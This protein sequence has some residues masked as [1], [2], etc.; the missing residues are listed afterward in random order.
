MKHLK[1]RLQKRIKRCLAGMACVFVLCGYLSPLSVLAADPINWEI[2]GNE[3]KYNAYITNLEHFWMDDEL[4]AKKNVDVFFNE[5]APQGAMMYK[6]YSVPGSFEEKDVLFKQNV[7]VYFKVPDSYYQTFPFGGKDDDINEWMTEKYKN[8][9]LTELE[10]G[11]EAY[12]WVDKAYSHGTGQR[13]H[14][15]YESRKSS[16]YDAYYINSVVYKTD[17]HIKN[18]S[19]IW[20]NDAVIPN[21]ETRIQNIREEMARE[22]CEALEEIREDSHIFC[23][24]YYGNNVYE[25]NKYGFKH[26]HTDYMEKWNYEVVTKYKELPNT[27]VYYTF[28]I[29]KEMKTIFP[30][31]AKGIRSDIKDVMTQGL[32]DM[33]SVET[34]REDMLNFRPTIIWEEPEWNGEEP[35][36][37]EETPKKTD[38]H[39]ETQ[40]DKNPGEFTNEGEEATIPEILIVGAGGTAVAIGGAAV[41]V[42]TGG[43]AGKK[44]GSKKKKG[45]KEE[46]EEEERKPSTFRMYFY[47]DFG[48][49]LKRGEEAKYVYARMVETTFDG[50]QVDRPDLS[51]KIVIS[52]GTQSFSVVEQGMSGNYKCALI[53][54]PE[55]F[56]ERMAC[57]NFRF[58]GEGGTY[59]NNLWFHVLGEPRILFPDG[60]RYKDY[61]RIDVLRG[62][63]RTYEV[64]FT[65]VDFINEPKIVR[66]TKCSEGYHVTIERLGVVE[67]RNDI[68]YKLCI[69]NQTY[70]K[71]DSPFQQKERNFVVFE[72][73]N[74]EDHVTA[75]VDIDLYPEGISVEVTNRSDAIKDDELVIHAIDDDRAKRL[76][77]KIL[78]TVVQFTC[79]YATE[80]GKTVITHEGFEVAKSFE[81]NTEKTDVLLKRWWYEIENQKT[82]EA[83]YAVI[84]KEVLSIKDEPPTLVRWHVLCHQGV[85]AF[86]TDVPVRLMGDVLDAESVENR[87]KEVELLL[88]TITRYD[89]VLVGDENNNLVNSVYEMA[90]NYMVSEA[91]LKQF[92]YRIVKTARDYYYKESL[93]EQGKSEMLTIAYYTACTLDWL[94]DQA[95]AYV[96]K[97]WAGE[98]DDLIMPWYKL[99][100][101]LLVD[102]THQKVWNLPSKDTFE[103]Q[104]MLALEEMIEAYMVNLL[105]GII[106]PCD[107]NGIWERFRRVDI[108]KVNLTNLDETLTKVFGGMDYKSVAKTS[109]VLISMISTLNFCKHYFD[110]QDEACGKFGQAIYATFCDC[111]LTA[112]KKT[113]SLFLEKW[114]QKKISR[115]VGGF[116]YTDSG[117]DAM[118]TSVCERILQI[119]RQYI[120]FDNISMGKFD[121]KLP[122]G[123]V[124]STIQDSALEFVKVGMEGAAE[125]MVN[126][127]K[128]AIDIKIGFDSEYGILIKTSEQTEC[129]SITCLVTLMYEW[130]SQ[131]LDFEKVA[132]KYVKPFPGIGWIIPEEDEVVEEQLAKLQ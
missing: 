73:L 95:F 8:G 14:F 66:T 44:S 132:L 35:E 107:A 86:M 97:C 9:E 15:I 37:K 77:Y 21:Y 92:R 7:H 70:K 42:A 62:D 54:V 87:A 47:K 22:N 126:G 108:S 94:G 36:Q 127:V 31:D 112:F 78:P 74:D 43:G 20:E 124:L 48:N 75:S 89:L 52:S 119:V 59:T 39:N 131:E 113:F 106:V 101:K 53:S 38:I 117:N 125:L 26:T 72:A 81:P 19:V 79:A 111:T 82:E 69:H 24:H 58:V 30:N 121:V 67:G 88:R 122:G 13:R 6:I 55:N 11:S 128:T 100:K 123:M 115:F 33:A 51:S 98:A 16:N 29:T 4:I 27:Y 23:R 105:F 41:A 34:F 85:R 118:T 110:E 61:E 46:K 28:D 103:R 50:K 71:M 3:N 80:D 32:A 76:D 114:L 116:H 56:N 120:V 90:N 1:Y 40:A 12:A 84:P 45:K 10:E 68:D 96:L 102:W 91:E 25:T 109:G 129:I 17:Y 18:V 104:F 93:R 83:I 99:M 130:L 64:L 63:D 65:L 2:Y 57:V 5:N 60:N 49:C